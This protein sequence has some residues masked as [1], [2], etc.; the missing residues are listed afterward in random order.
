M[1]VGCWVLGCSLLVVGVGGG[2][3]GVRRWALVGIGRCQ[4]SLVVDVGGGGGGGGRR[5][6]AGVGCWSLVVGRVGS[7]V[8]LG[9]EV[10]LIVGVAVGVVW[11]R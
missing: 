4:W 11:C 10:V 5:W 1:V 9:V 6:V 7:S 3:E 8:L 2:G